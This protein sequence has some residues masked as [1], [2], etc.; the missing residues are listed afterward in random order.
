MAKRE[1]R[2]AAQAWLERMNPL[3]GLSIRE[4]QGIFDAARDG[5][6]QR[7]HWLFQEIEA[8][9]P[10]LLVCVERR[11]S[12]IAGFRWTVSEIAA[13]DGA[14]AAEQKDAAERF[15]RGIDNF[16]DALEHLD[17]AFFRGFAHAQ[18]VWEADGT[19]REIVLL[20]SWKFV[21]RDGEWYYNPACTGFSEADMQPTDRCGLMS[22]VRRR[23]VDYPALGIHIRMAVGS[24]DWGRFLERYALPKPA[25]FMHPGATA[26]QRA[27]YLAG[28]QAVENGQVSVWPNGASLTDFAGGSRG[29]DPFSA[30]V[31]HQQRQIVLLATGGTLMS[32]AEAGTGTLAG[33]AQSE[34]WES[35]VARD[36]AVVA[37]AVRRAMLLPFLARAFPG[38]PAC[39]DFAFDFAKPPSPKEVFDT[40]AVARQAGWS[41]DRGQLEEQTGYTLERDAPAA[42]AQPPALLNKA[43][44]PADD[45]AE[46]PATAQA[47]LAEI[48]AMILDGSTPLEEALK[49]AQ[50]KLEAIDPSLLA[51]D[52]EKAIEEAM[53][54]AAAAA[55]E[56]A[57]TNKTDANGM[58]HAEAGGGDGE[59]TQE[60]AERIYEEMMGE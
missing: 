42:P 45:P 60:Q 52:L 9:N 1:R 51:A 21:R 50:R 38:R 48:A 28:A 34:V 57:A 18:P 39:V 23:P 4:A 54:K 8:A 13:R 3:A 53:F 37:Q 14:L 55:S 27:D 40:A 7:L 29:T 31:E 10:A 43:H 25:V 56:R 47:V 30:F 59:I 33:G 49:E 16:E 20:D 19:V 36:A 11:A 24:R 12:A 5:D 41:I 32:L 35:I 17:L 2:T 6:T 22:V 44:A 15:L 58:E 46:P 26:E